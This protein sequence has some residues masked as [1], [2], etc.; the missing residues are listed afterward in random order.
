MIANQQFKED[1]YVSHAKLATWG[2]GKVLEVLGGGTVRV[3]FEYEGEKKMNPEFLTIASIPAR[4]PV[5]HNIDRMRTV[6]GFIPF[7][8]LESAFLR[9]F[10][11][12]F[13]DP[14]YLKAERSYKV[15]ASAFLH[16][17]LSL[18]KLAPLIAQ[19]DYVTVCA[20]ATKVVNKINLI[21]RSEKI[22]FVDK[23]KKGETEQQIFASAL[24]DL[25]H[26]EEGLNIRFNAF[27][28]ALEELEILKWPLTTFFLFL[29]DP[30]SHIFVKPASFQTAARS[31]AFD[32]GYSTRPD[33][34]C[35]RRILDFIDYV[36]GQLSKRDLLRPRDLI[37]VQGFIWCSL[38]ED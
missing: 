10:P 26:G 8:N 20:L 7:P 18:N 2:V 25:L 30:N 37:D 22:T 4:H 14:L 29:Q 1:D 36:A 13:N 21:F 33:W 11:N 15:N 32:L 23:L 5:L 19:G 12:G 16:D 3:F 24:F 31:Y 17:L 27:C 9:K 34:A 35:Y 38:Y 6:K 28:A